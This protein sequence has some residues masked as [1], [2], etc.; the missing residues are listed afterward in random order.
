[1]NNSNNPPDRIGNQRDSADDNN[2]MVEDAVS[3][4][5]W[6]LSRKGE[7]QQVNGAVLAVLVS[8]ALENGWKFPSETQP[9][10][11]FIDLQLLNQL[12]SH[13]DDQQARRFS[14]ESLRA[15]GKQGAQT[16]GPEGAVLYELLDFIYRGAF[17]LR[18]LDESSPAG[19]LRPMCRILDIPDD[20]PT[21]AAKMRVMSLE[22]EGLRTVQVPDAVLDYWANFEPG[23]PEIYL[24]AIIPD[25]TRYQEVILVKRDAWDKASQVLR[26]FADSSDE[27]YE[28]QFQKVLDQILR[29]EE[30]TEAPSIT[31][32]V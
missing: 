6:E 30:F 23:T 29:A 21:P 15:V 14:R 11:N 13:F 10:A 16:L 17:D 32:S 4:F 2:I 20:L 26:Y 7:A 25:E 28:D 22:G 8:V 19:P 27:V 12:P 18:K 31:K 24:H 9:K 3:K 5:T 1:M